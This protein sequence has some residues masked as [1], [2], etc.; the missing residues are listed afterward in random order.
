MPVMRQQHLNLDY[1]F[2]FDSRGRTGVTNDLDHIRD[3]IKQFLFTS[4][5]ERVNRPDFGAGL[6]RMV[7]EP[8]RAELTAALQF[9]IRAGIQRWLDDLIEIHDL[10]V[11]AN[12]AEIRV[13]FQ[14]VVRRT[15][16][17]RQGQ[18]A[19]AVAVRP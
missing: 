14:Y 1:P 19:H 7:F 13:V 17:L 3:L 6:L 4:P 10:E 5:G 18:V 16:E 12:D 8:N 11:Q 15:G 9:T 2:H